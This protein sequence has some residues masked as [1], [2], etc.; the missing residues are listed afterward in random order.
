MREQKS[1]DIGGPPPQYRHSHILD[2][3]RAFRATGMKVADQLDSLSSSC[4]RAKASAPTQHPDTMSTTA[5]IH[6]DLARA[7]ALRSWA[8]VS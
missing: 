7:N 6:V 3:S 1:R 4:Q 5:G 2:Q 8:A